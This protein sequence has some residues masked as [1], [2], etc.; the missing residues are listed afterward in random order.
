MGNCASAMAS[1]LPC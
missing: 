1:Q